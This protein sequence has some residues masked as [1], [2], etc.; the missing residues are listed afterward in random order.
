MFGKKVEIFVYLV[1]TENRLVITKSPINDDDYIK[2]FTVTGNN[3]NQ[4]EIF[5]KL[6]CNGYIY[7]SELGI[8]VRNKQQEFEI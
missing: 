5:A 2:I 3:S 4:L 6:L 1:K 8:K 7:G